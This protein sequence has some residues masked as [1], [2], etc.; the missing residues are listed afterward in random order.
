[1]SYTKMKRRMRAGSLPE[2]KCNYE[3]CEAHPEGTERK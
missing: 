3:S 2:K 1:M